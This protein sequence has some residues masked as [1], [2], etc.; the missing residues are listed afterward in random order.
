[1]LGLRRQFCLWD[2]FIDIFFPCFLAVRRLR[3]G[4]LDQWYCFK[5]FDDKIILDALA[6]AVLPCKVS[7]KSL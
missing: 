5:T 4:N 2:P 6:K 3:N 7:G 1:M